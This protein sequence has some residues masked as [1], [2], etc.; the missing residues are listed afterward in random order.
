MIAAGCRRRAV[1][2]VLH[3][4]AQR[5]ETHGECACTDCGCRAHRPA[6]DGAGST[7]TNGQR[8]AVHG[9]EE[10]DGRHSG[11]AMMD[12]LIVGER[13]PRTLAQLAKGQARK[14]TGALEEAL[15]GYGTTTTPRSCR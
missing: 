2:N 9:Y 10:S 6:I 3:P 5:Q 8:D 13:D 14:K 15:R 12:A 4:I 11:R 7:R 1:P